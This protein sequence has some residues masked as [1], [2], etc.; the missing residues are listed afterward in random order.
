MNGRRPRTDLRVADH[1]ASWR[2][3]YAALDV[4]VEQHDTVSEARDDV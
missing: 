2:E 4:Q 3:V 1:H